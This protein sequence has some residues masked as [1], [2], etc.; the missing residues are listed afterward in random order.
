MDGRR[1]GKDI[2]KHHIQRE[3]LNFFC[4]SIACEILSETL[5]S[6]YFLPP[7]NCLLDIQDRMFHTLK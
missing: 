1:E 2:L 6:S 5:F 4:G 3:G 7:V